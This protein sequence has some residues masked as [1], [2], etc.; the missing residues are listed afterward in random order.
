MSYSRI[1]I[2]LI[3]DVI[4][5]WCPI[6][7]RNIKTALKRFEGRLDVDFR[8]LPYELNPNMPASGEPIDDYLRRRND[9]GQEELKRYRDKVIRTAAQAG[10]TY[11]YSKRTHYWN[12]AKAHTLLHI[13]EKAGKQEA[14]NEA[15]IEQ[16]FTQGLNVDDLDG[17][18]RTAEPLD[19]RREELERALASTQVAAEMAQKHARVRRLGIRTVPGFVI[20]ETELLTGSNSVDYFSDYL[21]AYLDE[22]AA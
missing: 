8:F 6:G 18:A 1:K 11:D 15:L 12:T 4:C 16:Y 19:I 7:Y 14:M 20:N 21:S 10:L 3:H 17:L 5:S 22:T 13:A 9:L 2:E